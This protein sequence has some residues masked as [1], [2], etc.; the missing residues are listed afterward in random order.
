MTSVVSHG[1]VSRNRRVSRVSKV[2]RSYAD[3]GRTSS[4]GRDVTSIEA[5]RWTQYRG[6]ANLITPRTGPRSSQAPQ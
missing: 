3:S 6:L 4:L 1:S 2:T 5:S